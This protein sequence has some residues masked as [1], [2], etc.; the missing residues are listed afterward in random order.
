MS[1]ATSTEVVC[2][3][4]AAGVLAHVQMIEQV[5]GGVRGIVGLLAVVWLREDA[6][7]SEGILFGYHRDVGDNL[8]DFRSDRGA[9][10]RGSLQL[11]IDLTTGHFWADVDVFNPYQ[12]LVNWIGHAFGEVIPGWFRRRSKTKQEAA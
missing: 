2:Q 6:R 1:R 5:D 10:G 7:F 9:C 4:E 11:V 3:L 12:D 8:T